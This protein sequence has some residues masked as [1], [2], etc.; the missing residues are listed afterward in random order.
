MVSHGQALYRLFRRGR[1]VDET[2]S[3]T[4]WQVSNEKNPGWLFDIGDDILPNIWGGFFSWLRWFDLMICQG[5]ISHDGW[6]ISRSMKRLIFYGFHVGKSKAFVPW[7]RISSWDPSS[8]PLISRNLA[9][10]PARSVPLGWVLQVFLCFNRP[11]QK[12]SQK[13]SFQPSIFRCVCC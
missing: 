5:F 9:F 11:S 4:S 13:I 2:K 12:P 7:I 3:C 6:Y 1:S 8:R 10:K